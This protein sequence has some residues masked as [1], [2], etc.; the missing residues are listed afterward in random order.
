MDYCTHL[1][2]IWRANFLWVILIKRIKRFEN[3]LCPSTYDLSL[4]LTELNFFLS[5]FIE[6]VN[7]ISCRAIRFVP[8]QHN[9]SRF[10]I[11]RL[12]ASWSI[13]LFGVFLITIIIIKLWWVPIISMPKKVKFAAIVNYIFIKGIATL[14]SLKL[15]FLE[16]SQAKHFI[17][18]LKYHVDWFD[19]LL[20]VRRGRIFNRF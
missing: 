9:I 16:W 11:D 14:K 17:I 12:N 20:E 8:V 7:S 4:I 15:F 6:L 18:L 5:N 13:T 1:F 19:C 10:F 2:N 3:T